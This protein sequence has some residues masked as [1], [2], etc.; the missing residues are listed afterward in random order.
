[1]TVVVVGHTRPLRKRRIPDNHQ[2]IFVPH[3]ECSAWNMD[4]KACDIIVAV[5]NSRLFIQVLS[6]EN[7]RHR[8]RCHTQKSSNGSF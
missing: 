3:R 7:K 8:R 2:F 6:I 5:D 1:I 4:K